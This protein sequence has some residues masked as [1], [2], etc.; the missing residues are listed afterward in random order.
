MIY[1]VVGNPSAWYARLL[2]AYPLRVLGF[3]SYG[4]YLTHVPAMSFLRWHLHLVEPSYALP[5]AV[6]GALLLVYQL[7]FIV[8]VVSI[9]Y[10]VVERPFLRMKGGQRS[11]SS[12]TTTTSSSLT[13]V[14]V[15]WQRCLLIAL[16][17]VAV[18]ELLYWR[19]V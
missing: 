5:G 16:S 6:Q 3:L 19:P 14:T 1:S 11:S 8:T 17:V 4:I 13:S 10:A 18:F 2:R 12:T 15:P 7:A 9:L